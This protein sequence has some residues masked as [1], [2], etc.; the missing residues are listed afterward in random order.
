MPFSSS[1][2]FA[3]LNTQQNADMMPPAEN[4]LSVLNPF[5]VPA[6]LQR[7]AEWWCDRLAPPT[8]ATTVARAI[9][10]ASGSVGKAV[11]PYGEGDA[12][13]KIVKF[14]GKILGG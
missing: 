9:T 4:D 3:S 13:E 12:A 7:I 5:Y 10:S 8:D 11:R 14:L 2:A 1:R 6:I